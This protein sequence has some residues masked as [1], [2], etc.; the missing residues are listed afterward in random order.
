MALAARGIH[1]EGVGWHKR[2][3]R[4]AC[5]TPPENFEG[6]RDAHATAFP[7]LDEAIAR[8][9]GLVAGYRAL[10][11]IAT[12]NGAPNEVKRSL[13]GQAL[14]VCPDCYQIRV[15][16][17]FGILP[18]WGGSY[19][20]MRAFAEES[21]GASAN[22]KLRVLA[23][24][25]DEDRCNR[26]RRDGKPAEALA[27]CN[28]ALTNGESADFYEE[29]AR[30]LAKS[31]TPAALADVDRALWLRPQRTDLLEQRADLLM[32][33]RRYSDHARDVAVLK[34]VDPIE[35]LDPGDVQRAAQGL[36]YEASQQGKAGSPADEIALLQRAIALEPDNLDNHR[37]LDAALV[38]AGQRQKIPAL[39][40]KYLARHPKDARA[41]FELAGALHHLGRE[42]EAVAEATTACHLGEQ[43]ACRV[44]GVRPRR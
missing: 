33:L 34:E 16:Y 6:M 31:N 9:P 2:G 14:A 44:P 39:W 20:M 32:R 25:P 10:I 19:E 18:R 36:A 12:A 43:V 15:V 35:R 27:A 29:R 26:L 42:P 13:L 3:G 23:G 7:D 41:H 22:P 1:H 38:R 17:M 21:A 5:E 8:R 4:W 30:L 28:R 11:R 40:T 37:R 24:Y